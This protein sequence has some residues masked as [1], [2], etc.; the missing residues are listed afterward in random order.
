MR[1]AVCSTFGTIQT[2]AVILFGRDESVLCT[3]SID[4]QTTTHRQNAQRQ[5]NGI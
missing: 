1:G 3:P 4:S 5:L 2:T